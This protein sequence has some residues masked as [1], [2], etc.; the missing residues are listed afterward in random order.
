MKIA[1]KIYLIFLI[2]LCLVGCSTTLP[3]KHLPTDPTSFQKSADQ[4]RT[5]YPEIGEYE[6]N[7]RGFPANTPYA[8]ELTSVWGEPVLINKDWGDVGLMG[9]TVVGCGIVFGPFPAAVA[10]GVV[11]IMRPYPFEYDY[12]KMGNYCIEVFMART[13]MHPYKKTIGYWKWYELS[14]AD[15][16]PKE[17]K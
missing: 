2:A 17:C 8:E 6:K 16:L 5:E 10:G 15:A 11:L 7:F 14:S 1:K 13:I 3:F 9:A 4:L 12:W